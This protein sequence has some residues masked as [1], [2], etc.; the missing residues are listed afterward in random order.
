MTSSLGDIPGS[1]ASEVSTAVPKDWALALNS[2]FDLSPNSH[3][4]LRRYAETPVQKTFF[5]FLEEGEHLAQARYHVTRKT[6]KENAVITTWTLHGEQTSVYRVAVMFHSDKLI[7]LK[8]N[9]LN[10]YNGEAAFAVV[11]S[12]C[13]TGQ[14]KLTIQASAGLDAMEIASHFDGQGDNTSAVAY[15]TLT[16]LS[17]LMSGLNIF[18]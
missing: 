4:R 7:G 10:C 16:Q 15:L 5:E 12:L 6:I 17:G 14:L 18:K 13:H 11:V 2:W 9:L 1:L 3:S 8:E